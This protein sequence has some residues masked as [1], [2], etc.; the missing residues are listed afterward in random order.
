MQNGKRETVTHC[1]ES[2]TVWSSRWDRELVMRF[3]VVK[4]FIVRSWGQGEG[5]RKKGG[6][7]GE[8]MGTYNAHTQWDM[9]T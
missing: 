3:V 6:R 9:Y 8:C 7:R 4:I 1:P 2:E 5:E